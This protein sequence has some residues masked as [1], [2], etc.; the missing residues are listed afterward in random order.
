MARPSNHSS[1]QHQDPQMQGRRK[2][3]RRT[4][5]A[6]MGETLRAGASS[7]FTSKQMMRASRGCLP[8]SANLVWNVWYVVEPALL[9]PQHYFAVHEDALASVSPN[10]NAGSDSRSLWNSKLV[11][12]TAA[13]RSGLQGEWGRGANCS[14]AARS[15]FVFFLTI[16]TC[17]TRLHLYN[18]NHSC[19]IF[20]DFMLSLSSSF[21]GYG[22]TRPHGS[23]T[24]RVSP[25]SFG[26][27]SISP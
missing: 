23:T 19:S 6:G 10:S 11:K 12:P 22:T 1:C 15:V 8:R 18:S 2:S 24:F 7:A 4:V 17:T 25:F 27:K 26:L 5:P 21:C 13:A 3:L 16:I 14:Y 9:T 20:L